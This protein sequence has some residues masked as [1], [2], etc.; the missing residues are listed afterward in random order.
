LTSLFHLKEPLDVHG[1]VTI[2]RKQINLRQKVEDDP[3]HP[4]LIQTVHGVCYR[5]ILAPATTNSPA[6]T[7]EEIEIEGLPIREFARLKQPAD[8]FQTPDVKVEIWQIIPRLL[9][10]TAKLA[11]PFNFGYRPICIE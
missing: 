10:S 1:T 4:T 5:L 6:K 2:Q 9:K 11:Q 3:S 7:E 8:K